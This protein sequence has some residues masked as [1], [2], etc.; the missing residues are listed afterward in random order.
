MKVNIYFIEFNLTTT[1]CSYCFIIK[2]IF[3]ILKIN[4]KRFSYYT[5]ILLQLFYLLKVFKKQ[6]NSNYLINLIFMKKVKTKII[7]S[8]TL[9]T[10]I[11]S[12]SAFADLEV[13]ATSVKD[14]S[15]TGSVWDIINKYEDYLKNTKD[16]TRLEKLLKEKD[17]LRN[18]NI[19]DDLKNEIINNAV[20]KA[21]KRW[22]DS[23]SELNKI[24]DKW[25]KDRALN[26]LK[27]STKVKEDYRLIVSTSLNIDDLKT[28]LSFFDNLTVNLLSND[29]TTWKN[30]YELI[31]PNKWK[32]ARAMSNYI[33]AG[34]IPSTLFDWIEIVQPVLLKQIWASDYLSWETVNQTWWIT[35]VW[36]EKYQYALSQKAKIKV[37]VIDTWIDYTHSELVSNLDTSLSKNFVDTT[38]TANDDHGHGTHVAWIIWAWVNGKWIFWVDS[39]VSLVALKVLSRDWY[40]SSYGI[41]DA[42]NYAANNWIKVINM[43]LGWNWTP[44]NDIICNAI[45]NAKAKWTISIV[46]A[47]NEN[48]DVST[49]VP[50]GCSDAITVWAVDSNLTKASFSNYWTEVDVSAP[51]VNIYST[52]KGNTYATMAWTSMATPFV[53]W[54]VWA[55]ISST[56]GTY[57]SVKSALISNWV[58]VNSSVNIG[59]FISMPNTMKSLWVADDLSYINTG[60]TNTGSTNTWTTNPPSTWSGI[61]NSGSTNTWVVTPPVNVLPTI[62]LN[63]VKNSTNN[64]TINSIAKDSDWTITS[65]RINKDWVLVSSWTTYSTIITKDTLISVKVTDNSWWT[66][67]ASTTLKYEAPVNILPT[68]SISSTKLATNN[69]QI[70]ANATDADWK[71]AWYNFFVNNVLAYSWTLNTYKLTINQNTAIKVIAIDNLWATATQTLNLTY[72]APIVTNK[73]PTIT[74]SF[75]TY[76]NYYNMVTTTAKDSDWYIVK[77]DVYL[78]NV[79]T[80]TYSNIRYNN[81]SLIFYT[82]KWTAYSVKT[83]AKDDKWWTSEN[84][85][86]V[87]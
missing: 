46:A 7:A 5:I 53:A 70:T 66:A 87:K 16:W 49:K 32:F 74:S 40:G 82:K 29:A 13:A 48:A 26:S 34:Q 35:K 4:L 17:W 78:N 55:I 61:T 1:I 43:S 72:E 23:D 80:Y 68:L 76:N 12:S 85:I 52:Y 6:K 75:K 83:V 14:V 69:Y 2:K 44:T 38:L 62:S 15:G 79:L 27:K 22:L 59:K 39:N 86:N 10:M 67:E 33:E 42:I 18:R 47:W 84:V 25:L 73:L 37:W 71:I 21:N 56:W 65:Y 30:T 41:V 51:G 77:L 24:S 28:T 31:F 9:A 8:L 60:T 81:I 50:A 36:A 20:F 64:Y 11:F 63:V 54:M 45:T 19:S 58:A 57:D 3:S